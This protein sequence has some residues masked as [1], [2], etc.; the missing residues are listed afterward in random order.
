M[1]NLQAVLLRLAEP[2]MDAQFTKLDRIDVDF[3]GRSQR[4]DLSD[5]TRVNAT[6]EEVANYS[7]TLRSSS[8]V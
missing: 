8:G 2:F 1:I 4:M 7:E 5:E 6:S 3:L